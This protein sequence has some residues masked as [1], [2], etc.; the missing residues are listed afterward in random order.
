MPLFNGSLE[1]LCRDNDNNNMSTLFYT[2]NYL[3]WHVLSGTHTEA[4][5]QERIKNLLGNY[6]TE[7]N[8]IAR[9][10]RSY[11][12]QEITPFALK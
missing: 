1:F 3:A 10:E 2:L 6:T 7:Q 4:V 9:W 8:I 12:P 5:I 11:C